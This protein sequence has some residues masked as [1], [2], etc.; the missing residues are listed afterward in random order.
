MRDYDREIRDRVRFLR[1]ALRESGAEGFVYGNSGGKDSALV[2]ILLKQASENTLG[3]VLPCGR[4][5]ERDIE[6]ALAVAGQ[7]GIRTLTIDLSEVQNAMISGLH[8]AVSLQEGALINI[9]P[10]LRMTALYAVAASENRLVAG[11]DNRSEIYMGYYTKWGDS[12]YDINPIA[13]LTVTEVY[14]CLRF[15][16]APEAVI[17]KA[18]SAGL[19]EGQTDEIE[20]GV[21]YQAIDTYLET[22]NATDDDRL[23]IERFHSRSGHKRR[24]PVLYPGQQGR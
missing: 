23:I 22:G 24:M 21:T 16:H 4:S 5:Q 2:G 17:R 11:T 3:L 19:Y 12:A 20:M 6:D 18:P 15:L 13:D 8:Q 9:A 14:E 1:E 7:Y 10:R